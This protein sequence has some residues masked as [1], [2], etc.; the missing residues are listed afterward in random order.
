MSVTYFSQC[1][2]STE[3]V[4]WLK[5][6][7]L[8]CP[9]CGGR[10]SLKVIPPCGDGYWELTC[11]DFAC[12][13]PSSVSKDADGVRGALE[14]WNMRPSR[15]DSACLPPEVLA[16][17][18]DPSVPLPGE[19]P[20]IN[21]SLRLACSLCL[22]SERPYWHRAGTLCP[23]S[24]TSPPPKGDAPGETPGEGGER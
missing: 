16:A 6:R 18:R 20:A 10:D 17:L 9:F 13:K 15:A 11:I 4:A 5:E 14:K 1:E 21:A 19:E 22:R 3:Q 2:T 24:A 7:M 8:P 12:P 23:Q